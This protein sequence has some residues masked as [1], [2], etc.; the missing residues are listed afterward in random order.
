MRPKIGWIMNPNMLHI[1]TDAKII[2]PFS[3]FPA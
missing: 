3:R 2:S 1:I